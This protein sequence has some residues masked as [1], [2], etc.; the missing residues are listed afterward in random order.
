MDDSAR[1]LELVLLT[2]RN[3]VRNC[4]HWRVSVLTHASRDPQVSAIGARG[5][6]DRTFDWV[7]S[8]GGVRQAIAYGANSA[9]PYGYRFDVVV[10]N[11]DGAPCGLY[12]MLALKSTD[13]DLPEVVIVSCHIATYPQGVTMNAKSYP[14]QCPNCRKQAL[15][16]AVEDV[17]A[18][19][20]HDGR[21]YTVTV[22]DLEVSRCTACAE[23]TWSYEASERISDALRVAAGLLMPAEIVAARLRLGVTPAELAALFDVSESEYS[24]W[25]SG[26]QLQSRDSDKLLRL[27]FANPDS[28]RHNVAWPHVPAVASA[29]S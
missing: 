7:N 29:V 3:G 2:F 5:V 9:V 12:V 4:V 28:F 8:V 6:I 11:I 16:P 13:K 21:P 18:E 24:R 20:H 17:T 23:S 14:H 22:P 1:Q 10:G 25:E 27:Y 19:L 26:G 15:F